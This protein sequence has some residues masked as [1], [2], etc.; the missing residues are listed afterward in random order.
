MRQM[1]LKMGEMLSLDENLDKN[2]HKI[3]DRCG[4][5]TGAM[6]LRFGHVGRFVWR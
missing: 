3:G 1:L 2:L 4:D 5:R 6:R